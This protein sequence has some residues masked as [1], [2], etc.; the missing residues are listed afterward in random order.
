MH[1]GTHME[2]EVAHCCSRGRLWAGHL[3]VARGGGSSWV[4]GL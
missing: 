3:G 1:W 4:L 2:L